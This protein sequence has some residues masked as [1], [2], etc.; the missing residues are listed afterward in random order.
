MQSARGES[1]IDFALG[2]FSG[3]TVLVSWK[4]EQRE[5]ATD[6]RRLTMVISMGIPTQIHSSV[7][8]LERAE[9]SRSPVWRDRGHGFR[10]DGRKFGRWVCIIYKRQ[11]T[12]LMWV[13]IRKVR[14]KAKPQLVPQRK[15]V[16]AARRQ[17]RRCVDVDKRKE[18]RYC[19]EKDAQK[20]SEQSAGQNG[21]TTGNT[22]RGRFG[23]T[24]W[25]SFRLVK[26]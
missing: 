25:F 1:W 23:K 17:C 18:Y 21:C 8:R 7:E 11:T 19:S 16:L 6:H 15:H 14:R 12:R 3:S 10:L 22:W 5:T 2:K 4:V 20:S 13:Q 9:T 26:M 24:L